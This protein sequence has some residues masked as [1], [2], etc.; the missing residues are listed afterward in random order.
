LNQHILPQLGTQPG[1]RICA[2]RFEDQLCTVRYIGALRAK[3]RAI[4]IGLTK[5]SALANVHAHLGI[6][7]NL[8]FQLWNELA[9][10]GARENCFLKL[11]FINISVFYLNSILC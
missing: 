7:Q 2:I 9:E 3:L 1:A 10:E 5:P 11:I 4:L 8:F 6:S